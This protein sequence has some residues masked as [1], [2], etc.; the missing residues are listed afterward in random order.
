MYRF[1][2]LFLFIFNFPGKAQDYHFG[3]VDLRLGGR[4][5]I[6]SFLEDI[7]GKENISSSS[8]GDYR[9]V[10]SYYPLTVEFF[11]SKRDIWGGPCDIY[12]MSENDR[13][14]LEYPIRHC[15]FNS[16]SINTSMVVGP[17][18][19]RDAFRIRACEEIINLN[20]SITHALD[21]A[22][23]NPD[24]ENTRENIKKVYSLFFPARP[25]SGD[26]FNAVIDSLAEV[27]NSSEDS[28]EGWRFILLVLCYDPSWQII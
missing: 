4:F 6:T 11:L 15:H 12:D 5:Y 14:M 9:R 19:V 23:L 16:S 18:V 3:N 7:F 8:Q 17:S 25:Q 24:S 1:L 2:I 22:G 27:Y 21:K 28:F 10:G 13:G 20:A 26:T